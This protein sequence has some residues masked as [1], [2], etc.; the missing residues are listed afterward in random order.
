MRVCSDAPCWR[1]RCNVPFYPW[2]CDDCGKGGQVRHKA[3]ATRAQVSKATSLAHAQKSPDCHVKA[4]QKQAAMLSVATGL[5]PRD[6]HILLSAKLK[7]RIMAD[8]LRDMRGG[9][10]PAPLERSGEAWDMWC[11]K[12]GPK[13]SGMREQFK[14][15][16]ALRKGFA[17]T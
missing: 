1:W 11:A 9:R 8:A 15:T 12:V 3:G 13:R 2:K 10:V 16:R 17:F 5:K 14:Q 7:R 4:L 6:R